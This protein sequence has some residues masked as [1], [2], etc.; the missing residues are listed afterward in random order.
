[1]ANSAKRFSAAA[2]PSFPFLDRLNSAGEVG[3]S[4]DEKEYP[5][6]FAETQLK[7][8]AQNKLQFS[9]LRPSKNPG[10]SAGFGSWGFGVA[11]APFI[12][13]PLLVPAKSLASPVHQAIKQAGGATQLDVTCAERAIG[14]NNH[15]I[16]QQI[17]ARFAEESFMLKSHLRDIILRAISDCK[18]VQFR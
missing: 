17:D 13:T 9:T 14:H 7:L 16:V 18:N 11:V 1:V 15:K 5:A 12:N 10:K 3:H 8:K 4:P 6:R 2:L